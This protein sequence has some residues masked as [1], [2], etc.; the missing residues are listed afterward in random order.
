MQN[1][2][3]VVTTHRGLQDLTYE[4]I[5]ATRCDQI[6]KVRGVA[7]VSRARSIALDRALLA[8]RQGDEVGLT[9]DMLLLVDD[10]MLFGPDDAARLVAEARASG[11]PTSARYLMQGGTP[12]WKE[13]PSVLALPRPRYHT[14]LGFVAIPRAALEAV[15]EKLSPVYGVRPWCVAGPSERYGAWVGEDIMVCDVF[16][17]VDLSAVEVGH[18]KQVALYPSASGGVRIVVP[19]VKQ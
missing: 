4:C 13:V 17:G 8:L 5:L 12:C 16:G 10:D 6:L 7:D 1:T 19:G 3:I 9:L 14:G 18:L 15:A 2:L 11:H